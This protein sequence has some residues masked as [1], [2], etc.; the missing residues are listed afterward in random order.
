[1]IHVLGLSMVWSIVDI[2]FPKCCTELPEYILYPSH[3]QR[4]L[5]LWPRCGF[6]LCDYCYQVSNWLIYKCIQCKMMKHRC[7]KHPFML[8]YYPPENHYNEYMCDLCK[9]NLS[10]K[11]RYYHCRLFNKHEIAL[12]YC[13]Y[14]TSLCNKCGNALRTGYSVGLKCIPYDYN[15]LICFQ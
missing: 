9:K 3:P 6:Y 1:M 13:T 7:D 4:L 5:K 10:P 15:I 8:N 14:D 12:V 11:W 2:I